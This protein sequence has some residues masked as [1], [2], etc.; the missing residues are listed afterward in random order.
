MRIRGKTCH[1]DREL[2][3]GHRKAARGKDGV[4][5]RA[6]VLTR[7]LSTGDVGVFLALRR[8]LWGDGEAAAMVADKLS[9]EEPSFR[10]H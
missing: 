4:R 2:R 3:A 6:S 1:C 9:E 7:G 8:G 10:G 5:T